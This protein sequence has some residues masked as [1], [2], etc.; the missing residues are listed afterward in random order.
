[1][2]KAQG[3]ACT[4]GPGPSIDVRI[5]YCLCNDYFSAARLICSR[6]RAQLADGAAR[7]GRGLDEA[8]YICECDVAALA[9]RVQRATLRLALVQHDAFRA[10]GE[11][12]KWRV[13]SARGSLCMCVCARVREPPL[14]LDADTA[15]TAARRHQAP[16]PPSSAACASV[17]Q[18]SF[19]SCCRGP[20][21]T[22]PVQATGH[23]GEMAPAIGPDIVAELRRTLQKEKANLRRARP[24][25]AA[26]CVPLA[27]TCAAYVR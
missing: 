10:S 16:P 11:P 3:A 18:C 1:M 23:C 20:H 17:A 19:G 13:Y 25:R 12:R 26:L 27:S 15:A 2:Q 21:P 14:A 7:G 5:I 24:P 9:L 6:H 4:S 22:T 8:K